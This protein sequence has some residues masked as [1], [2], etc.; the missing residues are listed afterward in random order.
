MA[1]TELASHPEINFTTARFVGQLIAIRPKTPKYIIPNE[2]NPHLQFLLKN[3]VITAIK[4]II[5]DGVAN[6]LISILN[7]TRGGT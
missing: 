5:N 7:G 4:I 6:E 3:I 1:R 2:V